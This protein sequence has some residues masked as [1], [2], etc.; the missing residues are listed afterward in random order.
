MITA[1]FG[2]TAVTGA[3]F[4]H[5]K[6]II[7]NSPHTK[8]VVVSAVGKEYEKDEKVTDLL[9]RYYVNPTQELWQKIEQKY[10]RL[11]CFDGVS[12]NV[13]IFL[14][15][16]KVTAT[17]S[18]LSYCLSLG[19]RL[20]AQ[21]VS[22]ILGATYLEADDL[23]VF[24]EDEVNFDATYANVARAF[25]GNLC[26]LGG[27][28]GKNKRGQVTT[29]ARGG[30]DITGAICAVATS[31]TVYEN[32]TDVC[33]VCVG[34]PRNVANAPTYNCLSYAQMRNLAQKGCEV[35]HPDAI[36]PVQKAGI[37]VVIGNFFQPNGAKTTI[38]NNCYLP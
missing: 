2:G 36:T 31:S 9:K 25:T 22:V 13:N 16:A 32:W 29:F 1:K 24:D 8:F 37:P 5:V 6:N 18:N 35:L 26:V 38:S 11:A 12:R 30:G 3:N 7:S 10:F 17:Q 21:I 4:C 20:S 33:G 23:V 34:N 19:E 27:F 14:Q 28:Y 15:Q